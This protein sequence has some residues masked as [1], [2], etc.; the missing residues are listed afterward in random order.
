MKIGD[1]GLARDIY[2]DNYYRRKGGVLPLRWM[3]PESLLDGVYTT[4]S[5]VWAFG[6]LLWEI[7][8]LGQRP[9]P[10]KS[11]TEVQLFVSRN[12]GHL[13]TPPN[14]PE[15]LSRLML[16]CWDYNPRLRPTFA[17]CLD[18][19]KELLIYQVGS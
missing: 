10:G 2:K 9:Y 16:K 13:E 18:E 17:Q 11:N 12:Q 14:C 1:F 6:V 19:V 8:T 15:R 4:Q 5:D 3:A 7:L